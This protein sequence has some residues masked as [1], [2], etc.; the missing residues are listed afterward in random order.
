MEVFLGLAKAHL[1]SYLVHHWILACMA[2]SLFIDVPPSDVTSA[3]C[4]LDRYSFLSRYFYHA[5]K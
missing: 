4:V 1:F 3:R 5:Y 2:F